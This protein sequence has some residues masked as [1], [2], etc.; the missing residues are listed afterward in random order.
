MLCELSLLFAV[1]ALRWSTDYPIS[2]THCG[3]L[4]C[5]T[6]NHLATIANFDPKQNAMSSIISRYANCGRTSVT[7]SPLGGRSLLTPP[8]GV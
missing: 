2:L 4:P 3:F 7:H 6:E 8:A 5:L 1:T